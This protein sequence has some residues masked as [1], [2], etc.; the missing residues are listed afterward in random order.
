MRAILLPALLLLALSVPNALLAE[1]IDP[2]EIDDGLHPP[3]SGGDLARDHGVPASGEGPIP[4]VIVTSRKLRPAF[5]KLGRER[6]RK[7]VPSAVRS[8]ESLRSDYPAAID[9]AERVRAFLR[10]AHDRW[11]TRWALIGG[12]VGEV[13]ARSVWIRDPLGE[14]SV[15]SD[16]Y[17]ACLD[18]TW[19][20]DGDGRYAELPWIGDPGDEPDLVAELAV[21]RAPVSDKDEARRFVDKTL[22]YEDRPAEG[23]ENRTLMFANVLVP[24]PFGVDLAEIAERLRPRITDDSAQQLTRLYESWDHPL[25]LP[26]AQPENRASVLA[27][28]NAGQNVTIGMGGGSEELLE[29]G[30][31][32]GPDPQLMTVSDAMGLANG[33]RAGHVWLLTSLVNAFD[34]PNALGEALVRAPNGGAVTVI[35]P[36]D[37][38]FLTPASSFIE[39]LVDV[40]F[41]E[42]AA[43]IGEA[44]VTA[45]ARMTF[46][47]GPTVA[48]TYQL[49]GDPLL[50]VFHASPVAAARGP[51]HGRTGITRLTRPGAEGGA[52]DR[53][54]ALAP[55]ASSEAP[56]AAGG[57]PVVFTLSRPAPSPASSSVRVECSIADGVAVAAEVVDLAGRSVRRLDPGAARGAVALTWDLRDQ[58]GRRV[59]PGIYFLRVRAGAESRA[60]RV[61]VASP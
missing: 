58:D 59:A 52:P 20:G 54:L 35:A 46:P 12:D 51:D 26:G 27:A 6:I 33:D 10:D 48:L 7:G 1:S 3:G 34:H 50:R 28:L 36:S 11:G 21:G 49:L 19:D 13:P 38:T 40:V 47:N 15:V 23:F 60:A 53:P 57:R 44:V 14:R 31:R 4:H 45:R 29:V 16:W 24:G 8:L 41:D 43:T 18:G 55:V 32:M 2:S 42:G 5:L 9:D 61:V 30:A 39:N 37:L 25:W 17:Y 22:A 56:A